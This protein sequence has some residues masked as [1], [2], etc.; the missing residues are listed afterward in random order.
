VAALVRERTRLTLLAAGL[1]VAA[2]FL[3]SCSDGGTA[4]PAGP[5]ATPTPLPAGQW[6]SFWEADSL[7]QEIA[8]SATLVKPVLRP[9]YLPAGLTEVQRLDSGDPLHF[10]I[11]Y[12]DVYHQRWLSLAAGSVGNPALAGPRSQRQQLVIRNTYATYQLYDTENPT[13]SAWVLWHEP[14]KWGAP[15]DPSLPNL[16]RVPYAM[17]SNGLSKDDLRKVADSLQP[18]EE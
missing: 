10:I 14:G 17:S 8:A 1:G 13:G 15:G 7:W 2:L 3:V 11:V 16:D 4:A 5:I 18:V 6:M 9:T 12:A